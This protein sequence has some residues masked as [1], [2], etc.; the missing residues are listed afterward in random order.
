M[1]PSASLQQCPRHLPFGA[2]TL[3]QCAASPMTI[4]IRGKTETL[5]LALGCWWLLD[6]FLLLAG[7]FTRAL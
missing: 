7:T 4:V 6:T 1:K 2:K 5:I 3:L